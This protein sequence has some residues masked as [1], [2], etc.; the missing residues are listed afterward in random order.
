MAGCGPRTPTHSIPTIPRP[1]G[2]SWRSSP[3]RAGAGAPVIVAAL[4]LDCTTLKWA[5][6]RGSGS[7]GFCGGGLG[8]GP[9]L[10]WSKLA[11]C[12]DP[13]TTMPS[14]SQDPAVEAWPLLSLRCRDTVVPGSLSFQ[15]PTLARP[16][17]DGGR[18]EPKV[19]RGSRGWDCRSG[20]GLRSDVLTVVLKHDCDSQ[21]ETS[22]HCRIPTAKKKHGSAILRSR[23]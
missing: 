22:W 18:E 20:L 6:F 15:E 11:S 3:R 12:Q 21:C 1:L 17:G 14:T 10:P 13:A 19:R 9:S 7:F 16:A 5:G 4:G 8:P 2:T 23:L